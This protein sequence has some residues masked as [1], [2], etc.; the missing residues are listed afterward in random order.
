MLADPCALLSIHG[1]SRAM[2][3]AVRYFSGTGNTAR[4]CTLVGEEFQAALWDVDLREL[5]TG[6]DT[7]YEGIEGA[8]LLFL[9]FPDLCFNGGKGTAESGG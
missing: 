6:Q 1:K 7:E 8:N 2:K 3:I 5:K 4:A 9:A